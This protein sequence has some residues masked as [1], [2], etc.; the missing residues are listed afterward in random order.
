VQSVASRALKAAG[1]YLKDN[2]QELVRVARQALSLK[3]GVPLA[4]L[5][6]AIKEFGGPSGPTDV[7]VEARNSG[8]YVEASLVLMHTPIRA[9]A[10]LLVEQLDVRQDAI[11]VDLRLQDLKL[12]VL[13]PNVGTPIA[14]LIQSGSL[15]TSRPGDLLSFIPKK[16]AVILEAHGD[17]FRLDLLKLPSL[18]DERARSLLSALAPLVNVR[19]MRTEEDHLDIAI[20]PLPSGPAAAV[21]GL[22]KLF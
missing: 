13:D 17:R 3:L 10:T 20:V 12:R 18:S 7:I 8:I 6:W 14:A 16:P 1:R 21:E 9:T 5:R 2:P 4:V 22:K 11:L 15:D 19:S